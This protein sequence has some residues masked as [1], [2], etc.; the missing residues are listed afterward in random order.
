MY[1]SV[2]ALMFGVGVAAGVVAGGDRTEDPTSAEIITLERDA[3]ERFRRG[4]PSRFLELSTAD[5][6]YFD[7]F[8]EKRLDGLPALTALYDQLRGRVAV[9][10][11]EMVDPKVQH[12]HDTA[13]LTFNLLSLG[14][15]R[16]ERWNCTEVYRHLD[17][18]WRIV[19]THWSF[20]KAGL[21]GASQPGDGV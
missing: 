8:Q 6:T 20:T 2:L 10:R 19:Q 1:R 11:F 4:D 5:V 3:L 16:T 18:R 21:T 17:G 15:A 7:P 13:V 9:D 12:W 14:G